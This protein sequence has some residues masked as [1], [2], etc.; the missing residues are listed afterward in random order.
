MSGCNGFFFMRNTKESHQ[1]LDDVAKEFALNDWHD[2]YAF[3]WL[4]IKNT[5]YARF[6]D[7]HPKHPQS[8][9]FKPF[10]TPVVLIKFLPQM[11]FIN[12][13]ALMKFPPPKENMDFHM[14]H[15]NGWGKDKE[16]KLREL[17][18]WKL[19]DYNQCIK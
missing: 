18:A 9:L 3:N 8:Y 12:G 6:L 13:H 4:I 5:S 10:V 1:F 14:V 2:Q 7:L 19:D 15:T 17:N 11:S 16:A